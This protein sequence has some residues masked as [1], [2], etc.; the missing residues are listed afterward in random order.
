MQLN[1]YKY[2]FKKEALDKC[3]FLAKDL[4][5]SVTIL[6]AEIRFSFLCTFLILSPSSYCGHQKLSGEVHSPADRS[7]PNPVAYSST[8]SLDH[9]PPARTPFKEHLYQKLTSVFCKLCPLNVTTSEKDAVV[10]GAQEAVCYLPLGGHLEGSKKFC[11]RATSC[12]SAQ[13]VPMSNF[14]FS[15]FQSPFQSVTIAHTLR[16][17]V[18]AMTPHIHISL[19]STTDCAL[20]PASAGQKPAAVA[21]ETATNWAWKFCC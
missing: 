20:F 7:L 4:A 9:V 1:K 13:C 18:W 2:F 19:P 16:N 8:Y 5:L 14:T 11:L 21:S 12:G 15:F 17:L 3:W 6:T 10:P